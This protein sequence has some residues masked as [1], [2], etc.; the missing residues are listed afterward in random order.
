MEKIAMK[1]TV[2]KTKGNGPAKVL[3]REGHVPAVLY[4]PDAKAILLSVNTRDFENLIKHRNINQLLLNLT[5][6]NGQPF[7]KA[8]MI[9]ELQTHPVSQTILHIDFYEIDM[10]RKIRVNVPVVTTGKSI[11]VE[12]GGVVQIIRRDLEVFC[13]PTEIPEAIEI[14]ISELNMGQSVHVQEI[15]LEDNIE[16]AADVNFTVVTILSPKVDI[17]LDEEEAAAEEAAAAAEEG[18]EE[19]AEEAPAEDDEQ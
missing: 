12:S 7:T 6:E 4:G 18:L 9:K 15:P 5:I 14:D 13:M 19:G 3:R 8:V 16:I 11:G 17:A 10:K 1:A 2:R